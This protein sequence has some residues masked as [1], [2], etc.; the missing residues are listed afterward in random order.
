MF[1]NATQIH[2]PYFLRDN[3]DIFF[4]R[5]DNELD[6]VAVTCHAIVVEERDDVCRGRITPGGAA[7]IEGARAAGELTRTPISSLFPAL[8]F[9]RKQ[10]QANI[11]L[12]LRKSQHKADEFSNA[13]GER[14]DLSGIIW[15]PLTI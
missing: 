13:C 10:V 11:V 7:C 15:D 8:A 2:L 9:S 3:T 14:H 1:A 5:I 12:V 6:P 4:E